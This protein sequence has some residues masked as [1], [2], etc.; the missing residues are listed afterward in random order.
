M[1]LRNASGN[2]YN[3]C[4]PQSKA[5]TSGGA[6]WIFKTENGAQVS[7]GGM[8]TKIKTTTLS[9]ASASPAFLGAVRR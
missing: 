3:L 6:D 5:G 9:T 7:A 2:S 4:R 1:A 8:R